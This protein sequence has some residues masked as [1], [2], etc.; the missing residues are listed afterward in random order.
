MD[1]GL[2]AGVDLLPQVA[3]VELDHMGLPAEVIVP[4][5]VEDLSLGQHP[6]RV[7]HEEAQQLEL[8]RGQLDQLPPRRTSRASSSM[9]R[10]P[11]TSS[12]SLRERAIPARR[13]SPRS[14]A[15]T[16]SRLN[17]FVT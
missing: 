8:R 9:V 6:A 13:S 16:S 2:P 1:Q 17:G 10:S 11:T 12:V 14:R 7:A 5:P 4:D 3:D 15:S